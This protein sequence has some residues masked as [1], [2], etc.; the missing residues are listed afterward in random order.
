VGSS[1]SFP[2]SSFCF[3]FAGPHSLFLGFDRFVLQNH[4]LF[5][6]AEQPPADMAALLGIFRSSVPPLV[7][8]RMKELL[9]TIKVAVKRGMSMA[10]LINQGAEEQKETESAKKDVVMLDAE[11][12]ALAEEKGAS[13]QQQE[14]KNFWGQNGSSSATTQSSLFGLSQSMKAPVGVVFATSKSTLFGDSGNKIQASINHR[15]SCSV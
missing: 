9:S 4:V 11:M 2:F 8:R 13:R 1:S 14:A 12:K 15:R 6:L 7:K 10:Q 5:L 3:L